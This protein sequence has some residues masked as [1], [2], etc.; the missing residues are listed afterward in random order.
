[1]YKHENLLIRSTNT[2]TDA[3]TNT[4]AKRTNP[5]LNSLHNAAGLVGAGILAYKGGR[6]LV[7]SWRERG[8]NVEQRIR[9][10]EKKKREEI[11]NRYIRGD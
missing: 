6:Y 10:E 2:D 8:D 11:K 7:D 5:L 1:M 9:E 4:L 3:N